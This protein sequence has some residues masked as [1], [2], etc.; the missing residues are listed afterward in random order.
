MG[1]TQLSLQR[2]LGLCPGRGKRES[3]GGMALTSHTT[4]HPILRISIAISLQPLCFF[5]WL[6]M[7]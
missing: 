2:V 4:E 1:T 3:G 6:V 7:G 5:S